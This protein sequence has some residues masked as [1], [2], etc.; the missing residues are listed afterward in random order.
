MIS[1]RAIF[2]LVLSGLAALVLQGCATPMPRKDDPYET[3]N[4]RIYAFNQTA[5]RVAI[6]PVA[7]GYRKVTSRTVRRLVSN[8]YAN[9]EMPVSIGNELL[10]ARPHAALLGTCRLVINTTI[11]ILGF[12][13][14]ASE[15]GILSDDTDFSV[16]LA[17]WGVPDGPY[18]V[19]PLLGPTTT[20]DMWR[21]PVDAYL[22]N[23]LYFYAKAHRYPLHAQYAP[24][25]L[26]LVTLRSRA[27][28]AE[29]LLEGAYDPYAFYRDAY[30]QRQMYKIYHGEPPLAVIQALQGV[31]DIDVDQ[32]LDEQHRYEQQHKPPGDGPGGHRGRGN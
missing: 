3:F 12:L 31:D 26:Y 16:T 15:I 25:L 20:R 8:F 22:L 14:P 9:V 7:A 32:L 13:D 17:R 2:R 28:D 30:R 6:R 5:D 10:Q 1:R 24:T 23:P 11:G 19:L 29:G 4:R 27:I 21:L 18:L